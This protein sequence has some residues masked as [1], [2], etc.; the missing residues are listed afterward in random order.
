[1]GYVNQKS[2]CSEIYKA[3]FYAVMQFLYKLS[4]LGRLDTVDS[5]IAEVLTMNNRYNFLIRKPDIHS[6]SQM[7]LVIGVQIK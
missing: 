2:H 4:V 5:S 3:I 1:M 7:T 6:K